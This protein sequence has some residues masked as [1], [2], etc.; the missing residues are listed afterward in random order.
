M[1]VQD[2]LLDNSA[3]FR[4]ICSGLCR[5]NFGGG[6]KVMVG[7]VRVQGQSTQTPENFRKFGKNFVIKLQKLHYFSLL[8]KKIKNPALNFRAFGR[9]AQLVGKFLMK[10]DRKIK[11]LSIL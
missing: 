9:K 2:K 8:F 4:A 10:F 3:Q 6:F 1:N 7:L 5:K 11:F